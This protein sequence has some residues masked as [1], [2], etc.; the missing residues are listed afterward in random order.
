MKGIIA[1]IVFL[2]M[3]FLYCNKYVKPVEIARE[4][5]SV[6]IVKV[7]VSKA[8]IPSRIVGSKVIV[9]KDDTFFVFECKTAHGA[10]KAFNS[11]VEKLASLEKGHI[12]TVCK[13]TYAP[14]GNPTET[15]YVYK[16]YDIVGIVLD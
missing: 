15:R 7:D 4:N 12:D 11:S 8:H 16:L 2:V 5:I 3:M 10:G 13:I 6:E 14:K 9:K 1:C